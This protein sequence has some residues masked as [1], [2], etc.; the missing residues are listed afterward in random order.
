MLSPLN[1]SIN[2]RG[3]ALAKNA[4]INFW[5]LAIPYAVAFIAIPIIIR[6]LGLERFGILSL[7]WVVIG[8]FSIVDLGLSRATTKYVAEAL[9]R[10]SI[11]EIPKFVWTTVFLQC[12]LGIIGTLVFIA[13]TPFLV[14]RLLNIPHDYFLEAKSAFLIM[15]LSLPIILLSSSFRGIL[16]AAQKFDLINLI[17]VPVSISMYLLPL[18]GLLLGFNLSGIVVLFVVARAASLL[19]WLFFCIKLFPNLA[20]NINF[21]IATVKLL[22]NFGGWAS[23]SSLLFYFMNSADRFLIGGLLTIKELS[24]YSAPLEIVSRFSIIPGSLSMI[25]FPAFSTLAGSK[26]DLRSKILYVRSIKYIIIGIGPIALLFANY[27]KPFLRLWL[28][29]LFAVESSNVFKFLCLGF[30]VSSL[31]SIPFNFLFGIG[32]VKSIV[33]IQ[34]IEII[35]YIPLATIFIANWGINGAAFA[36]GI[37]ALL[38]TFLYFVLSSKIR[39]IEFSLFLEWGVLKAIIATIIFALAM[40]AISLLKNSILGLLLILAFMAITTYFYVLNKNEKNQLVKIMTALAKR[41]TNEN[42]PG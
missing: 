34:F 30:I 23:L 29:P 5:G 35:F 40:P 4:I 37:K 11:Q 2:V 15:G 20:L 28:G 21:H 39:K 18:F 12:L 27:S 1:T 9:G 32:K 31:S 19:A 42:S 22:L 25:L 17:K 16:E 26:E 8:Y 7:I 41:K 33:F 36:L 24:F 38:I 14:G 13:F 6:K 3:T 10:G